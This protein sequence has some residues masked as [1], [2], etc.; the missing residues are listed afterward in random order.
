MTGHG[1]R[2]DFLMA[3]V[4]LAAYRH[5]IDHLDVNKLVDR[6]RRLKEDTE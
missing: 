1:K 4:G 3:E 5:D 6:F 2:N